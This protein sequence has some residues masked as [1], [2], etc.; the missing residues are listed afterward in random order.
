MKIGLNVNKVINV[1][2]Q[3]TKIQNKENLKINKYD[4]VELSVTGKE[5][6]KYIEMAKCSSIDDKRVEEIKKAIRNNTYEINTEKL[7][8]SILNTMKDSDVR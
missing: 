4:R 6:S 7:A 3:N 1:Y 8:K 5:I 2:K